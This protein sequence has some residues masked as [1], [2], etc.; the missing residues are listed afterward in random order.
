VT[1]AQDF[2]LCLA[3]QAAEEDCYLVCLVCLV[4]KDQPDKQNKPDKPERPGS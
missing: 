2:S 4:K 3:S 1:V